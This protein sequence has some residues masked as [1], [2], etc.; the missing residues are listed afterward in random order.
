MHKAANLVHPSMA[1]QSNQRLP[2]GALLK[3]TPR[4]SFFASLFL[5]FAFNCSLF[6]VMGTK[7]GFFPSAIGLAISAGAMVMLIVFTMFR[8]KHFKFVALPNAIK[9]GI[10]FLSV[11]IVLLSVVAYTSPSTPTKLRTSIVFKS[12]GTLLTVFALAY[13][14]RVFTLKEVN[15]ALLIFAVVESIGCAYLYLSNAD[16]NPNAISVR[17]CVAGMCLFAVLER[18]YLKIAAIAISL[19][20]SVLLSCRT[21]TVALTGSITFLL[22]ERYSRRNRAL[23]LVLTIAISLVFLVFMPM[24]LGFAEQTAVQSLGSDHPVAKFFL[25]DK[26][27]AKISNDF[28][29]RQDTWE[30]SY[31]FIKERPLFGHGVGTEM[32]FMDKRSHCAYMSL[33]FEGGIIL[34]AAWMNFYLPFLMN[35]FNRK[36]VN[37]VG[38]ISLYFLSM[39]LLVYMLLAGVVE[40]S[41]LASVSTPNNVIFM[42]LVIWIF[43]PKPDG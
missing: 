10:V 43:Q 16:V 24:I 5:G 19:A 41:G 8:K 20:F 12:C 3:R 42:F 6:S 39:L 15:R 28:L 34:L 25:H 11:T 18:P 23:V 32:A 38:D 22:L 27:S 9:N 2:A 21:S 36:W 40:T 31:G 17:A 7:L 33:V 30:Q 37:K 14:A 29:D 26:T 13:S 4:P 35:L 1:W